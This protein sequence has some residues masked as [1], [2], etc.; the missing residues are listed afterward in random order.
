MT[1]NSNTIHRATI[2]LSVPSKNADLI[3]Y[4]TNV[5][6]KMTGNA[7]FP[8]P[9]PTVS[10]L[11]A[12]IDDL[13]AAETATLSR[14]KGT[15][16]VRND[17]RTVLVGLLQQLRGYVQGVADGTPENAAAIIESAGLAVRKIATRGKQAFAV[18]QG[19]LSGSAVVTA[20]SAGPRSAY[21][22]EYSVDGGKTW[23][24]APSTIQGK[25]TITGLAAG[26]TAMFRYRAVTPKGGQGDWSQ[27]L[28]LLVK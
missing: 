23:V 5:V 12:A 22:W 1:T 13:H 14:A 21:E 9:T 17:K 11:T 15:V 10:A 7:H 3:L 24:A 28:A 4:G 18:K 2:A 16:T 19:T 25:T 26:T 20:V 27:P 8:T 6:Q